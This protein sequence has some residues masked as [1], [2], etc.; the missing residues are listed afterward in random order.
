[1]LLE[2]D[3]H[4]HVHRH[5]HVHTCTF[6]RISFN[7]LTGAEGVSKD[8]SLSTSI[9]WLRPFLPLCDHTFSWLADMKAES[10]LKIDWE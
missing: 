4:I 5:T 9:T 1:M 6:K 7:I 2:T 10:V 8:P 3:I